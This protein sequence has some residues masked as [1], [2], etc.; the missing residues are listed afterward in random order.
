MDNHEDICPIC[1][2]P[3]TRTPRIVT[4]EF[5]VHCIPCNKKKE[6]LIKDYNKSP[7]SYG[8]LKYYEDDFGHYGLYNK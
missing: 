8:G 2:T 7:K 6:D 1:K 5:W 4:N 3:W